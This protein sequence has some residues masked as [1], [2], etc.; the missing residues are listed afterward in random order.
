MS[1]AIE[2]LREP[3]VH[4]RSE[5]GTRPWEC[6]ACLEGKLKFLRRQ[7]SLLTTS[8]KQFESREEDLG[9]GMRLLKYRMG[10]AT[11]WAKYRT[12][13]IFKQDLMNRVEARLKTLA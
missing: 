10:N 11:H 5:G 3:C 12:R 9:P 13:L 8:L 2:T 7:V 4:A 1:K 6:R